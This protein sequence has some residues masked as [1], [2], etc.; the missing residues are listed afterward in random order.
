MHNND[1]MATTGTAMEGAMVTVTATAAMVSAMATAM[2]GV[3]AVQ[4]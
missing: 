4:W 2:D 3:T 1:T